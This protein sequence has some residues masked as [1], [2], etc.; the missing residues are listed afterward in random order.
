MGTTG[1]GRGCRRTQP[2]C[3][4]SFHFH[5]A[6]SLSKVSK[7]MFA[8]PVE[9]RRM[10]CFKH[11][12]FLEG[13]PIQWTEIH[14]HSARRE[15]RSP[16]PTPNARRAHSQPAAASRPSISRARSQSH[17]RCAPHRRHNAQDDIAREAD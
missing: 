11:E 8:A 10:V 1:W 15:D 9:T 7:V 5:C 16:S 14:G 6:V 13:D 12:K 4:H 3:A 2:T 17:S